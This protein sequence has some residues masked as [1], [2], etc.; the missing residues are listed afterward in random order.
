[1]ASYLA[2][3]ET[4]QIQITKNYNSNAFKK[5]MKELFE[6]ISV[7]KQPTTFIFSD[8]EIIDDG[9]IEDVNNILGLGEI[10][11][12]F[13]KKDGKDEFAQIKDKLKKY[14]KKQENDE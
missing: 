2:K 1:M 9:I 6:I 11:N 8:N 10:P 14:V 12:L 4:Y 7:E 3:Y 5:N 13:S